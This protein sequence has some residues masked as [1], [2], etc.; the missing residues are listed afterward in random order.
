M[1]YLGRCLH[2]LLAHFGY[3]I[4]DVPATTVASDGQVDKIV[5]EPHLL[6]NTSSFREVPRRSGLDFRVMDRVRVSVFSRASCRSCAKVLQ[7]SATEHN[8]AAFCCNVVA[9]KG[10]GRKRIA[11]RTHCEASQGVLRFSI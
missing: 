9:V 8:M 3:H 5:D 6:L 11:Y 1:F 7:S 4:L 10:K 2:C